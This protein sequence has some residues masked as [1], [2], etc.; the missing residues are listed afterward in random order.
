MDISTPP[1][2]AS[3]AAASPAAA[4][5]AAAPSGAPAELDSSADSEG[6]QMV[7][8][9]QVT[10][11]EGHADEAFACVWSPAS[12]Q[13]ASGS[14]DGTA[15]I[16]N[17][18]Q[19]SAGPG[20]A[21]ST[22]SCQLAHSVGETPSK[23]DV[24]TMDWSGDGTRLATG[25]YDGIARIWSKDGELLKVLEAHKGPI[26]S[27]K[28]S[29]NG[30]LLLSG[31]V[32]RS[33]IVWEG[34]TGAVLQRFEVHSA[35]NMDVDWGLGT[36]FAT[37]SSDKRIFICKVGEVE[38]LKCL[39]GHTDEVNNVKWDPSGK[40]LAS[41]SDDMTARVWSLADSSDSAVHVLLGHTK[42]I[43]TLRWCPTGPSS[44]NPELPAMFVTGSFDF[45]V[46]L[47]DASSGACLKTMVRHTEAVYSVA[48][49]PNGRYMVSG[50]FD[51]TVAVWDI[52]EGKA[53]RVYLGGGGVFE[54]AW[55]RGGQ[56]VAAC[57]SDKT[58]AV[59][60]MRL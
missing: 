52:L 7:P 46:R 13:L 23:K 53:V 49:S 40:L 44:N 51:K 16:W 25:S 54:V 36:T 12:S 27:L 20:R 32:D 48:V 10:I 30:T 26:F 24:T 9:S 45:S 34:R 50:S 1:A 18:G 29:R 47:W 22:G 4:G 2:A 19:L 6:L 55:E 33:A 57:F 60:N 11:L 3:P 37:C 21:V 43:Y 56:H 38:P 35:P 5:E 59:I 42:E 17:L 28:W 14:G 58:V 41:C 39:C 15:R 31:S 8:E